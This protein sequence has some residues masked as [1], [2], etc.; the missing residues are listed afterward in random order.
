MKFQEMSSV[1][2]VSTASGTGM[3]T[4]PTS[5]FVMSGNSQRRVDRC[6]L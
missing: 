5:F 4:V 2:G 1:S 3:W 6:P